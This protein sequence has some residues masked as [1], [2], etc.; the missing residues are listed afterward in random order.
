MAALLKLV[1]T[2]LV[3][4]EESMVVLGEDLYMEYHRLLELLSEWKSL[5]LFKISL[6]FANIR[7]D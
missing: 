5:L 6:H 4:Q 1:V 7:F 3:K 2:T